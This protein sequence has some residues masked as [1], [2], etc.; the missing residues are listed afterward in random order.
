MEELSDYD[1][2]H[3]PDKLKSP[4]TILVI[5]DSEDSVTLS[6]II[7]EIAGYEV[8]TAL[9]GT[10]GLAL[11]SDGP[12]IDLI[13]LDMQLGDISGIEFLDYLEK[14]NPLIWQSV[15]VIFITGM[16]NVPKSQAKAVLCKPV[17]ISTLLETVESFLEGGAQSLPEN[18]RH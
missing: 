10:A 16:D 9:S 4:K 3:F 6:K 13:L 7:L 5:D 8:L 12:Q 14:Q 18:Q 11:L 15:P 17:E 1:I 2:A